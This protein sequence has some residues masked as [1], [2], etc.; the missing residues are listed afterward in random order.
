MSTLTIDVGL[1]N[2]ALCIM[3]S[4]TATGGCKTGCYDIE[5]WDV[6]NTLE[7]EAESVRCG[8]LTKTGKVCGKKCSYKYKQIDGETYTCKPHFP[9]GIT[10]TAKNK[11]KIKRVNEYL[12]QDITKTILLKI[13]SIYN[14]NFHIFQ[15]VGRILIELQ[16]K[17]NNKMKLISHLIY[18]KFVEIYMDKDVPIRFVKASGKLKVYRGPVIAC[19]LKDAYSRRKRLSIEYTKWFLGGGDNSSSFNSADI[20]TTKFMD[21]HKKDDLGDVFLMA[22]NDLKFTGRFKK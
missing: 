18:G 9:K 12:L 4:A 13:T 6:Y 20:W 3:S 10:A 5:L 2:L 21:S 19:N 15:N 22:L 14:E 1:K 11:V 17:I 8:S 7:T 16:P